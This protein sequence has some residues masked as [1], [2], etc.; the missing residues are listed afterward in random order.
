MSTPKTLQPISN[1]F[2]TF[3]TSANSN[4]IKPR[5]SCASDHLSGSAVSE[6]RPRVPR[7]AT[8]WRPRITPQATPAAA[9]PLAS[10]SAAAA[11]V[12]PEDVEY[13]RK[14]MVHMD[15]NRWM[16]ALCRDKP[17]YPRRYLM[18][19]LQDE[20][21]SEEELVVCENPWCG[22]RVRVSQK[23]THDEECRNG[24]WRKCAKCGVA[25]ETALLPQHEPVCP[26]ERCLLCGEYVLKV[27]IPL[28]P[29]QYS[30]F[31]KNSNKIISGIGGANSL[32]VSSNSLPSLKV[33]L[34][35]EN[36]VV[37]TTNAA[38]R[39]QR[40]FRSYRAQSRFVDL[41]FA[42]IWTMMDVAHEVEAQGRDDD[43][44]QE[45]MSGSA[46]LTWETTSMFDAD[47]LTNLIELVRSGVR[48]DR[49]EAISA[50]TLFHD[51]Y[52][53][54]PSVTNIT[55]PQSGR[56]IVVGD[57]HGEIKDL[58]LILDKYGMPSDTNYYVFNG[59]FVDRGNHGC[60]VL[61]MLYAMAAVNPTRVFLIRGNH[62]D[63]KI[64]KEYGFATEC[65]AKYDEEMYNIV[66][67]SYKYLP[68][69][70]V[71][72]QKV[73][74]VH[75][76]LHRN[77]FNISERFVHP[78]RAMHIP[79]V[80]QEDEDD[81]LL[82][83]LLWSDPVESFRSRQLGAHHQ[84]TAWRTNKRG[85]GLEFTK[86]L[87]QA[88]L[89]KNNLK[90]IIRSHEV[91]DGGYKEHHQG[92]VYTVFSS[93][94]YCGVKG[95]RGAV[96]I[97][98][99][100]QAKPL[101]ETWY[102]ADDEGRSLIKQLRKNSLRRQGSNRSGGSTSPALGPKDSAHSLH[103]DSSEEAPRS[104]ALPQQQ[105]QQ[106]LHFDEQKVETQSNGSSN[107]SGGLGALTL[108]QTKGHALSR[109]SLA[110]IILTPTNSEKE[111]NGRK[112]RKKKPAANNADDPPTFSQMR[113]RRES[114][115]A[116]EIERSIPICGGN[117]SEAHEDV[118]RTLREVIWLARHQLMLHFG[119]LDRDY[120][121]HVTRVEW[122][123]VLENTLH[124]SLPWFYLS[125]YLVPTF[126]R[127]EID[128]SVNYVKFLLQFDNSI[129]RKLFDQ[130]CLPVAARVLV[131]LDIPD[132]FIAA[133]N[134]N[135]NNND[136]D[137]GFNELVSYERFTSVVR[138][139]STNGA[140]LSDSQ[141]FQLFCFFD[142]DQRGAIYLPD[143]EEEL[144]GLEDYEDE[145]RSS[146]ILG[147]KLQDLFTFGRPRGLEGVF[148]AL[149]KDGDKSLDY[150]E[151]RRAFEAINK[152][153]VRPLTSEQMHSIFKSIDSDGSGT[154][155]YEEFVTSFTV[156][157]M[158]V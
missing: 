140:V 90:Y 61:F 132:D 51:V 105:Q 65:I 52:K 126:V 74:V 145:D 125:R 11:T 129:G 36:G 142:R 115:H 79:T 91:V 1:S 44:F 151:F 73:L 148:H 66:V 141:L 144:E 23:E 114:Q 108:P 46:F 5:G 78:L 49:E 136:V 99:K 34:T 96:A 7:Q 80:Q 111:R 110:Q 158:E 48:I 9:P 57:I 42:L 109:P 135:N 28:C 85:C 100:L 29:L 124:L 6:G 157:Q 59:D 112:K 10:S 116:A 41:S 53:N 130:W 27:L 56:L 64:N 138:T 25:M 3:N 45:S 8:S 123:S 4:L 12:D 67:R 155:N 89:E 33:P 47:C 43:D 106:H 54:A 2:P 55:I 84:G 147:S 131:P 30:M 82:V 31:R 77:V 18:Q 97:L 17:Q 117:Q 81:Q 22:Q 152:T 72:D 39:I 149:D 101:F 87:T 68:L 71:I 38:K 76:G 113:R 127:S 40:A 102:I 19:L 70:A 119:R 133:N 13:L 83:D 35:D 37:S 107:G 153:C 118:M 16:T 60:E 75:G 137:D 154:I 103:K 120:T 104:P 143:M 94:N 95:N 150:D 92:L 24:K 134:N 26:P 58:L 14:H 156:Y 98:D 20:E 88:F 32:E 21:Y 121:G 63:R 69:M 50:I 62:E 93:S 146:M 128:G 122:C 86:E 139:K 15:V